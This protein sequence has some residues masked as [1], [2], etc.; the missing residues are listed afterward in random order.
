M[1]TWSLILGACA[2]VS[3]LL[4]ILHDA[5][6]NDN[7]GSAILIAGN[8]VVTL[9]R[10]AVLKARELQK[11]RRLWFSQAT[12]SK[13][14]ANLKTAV[15]TSS[16]SLKPVRQDAQHLIEQT[17]LIEQTLDLIEHTLAAAPPKTEHTLA[18]LPNIEQAPAASPPEIEQ[19]LAAPPPKTEHTLAPPPK[20]EQTPAAPPPN[21][22]QTPAALPPTIE[23]DCCTATE[24]VVEQGHPGFKNSRRAR[25]DDYG[26]GHGCAWLRSLR[27]RDYPAHN[28]QI[29]SG[30]KLGA[31][32]DKVWT[33][34]S[35]NSQ[36]S[37]D[38]HRRAHAA[39]ISSSRTLD[40]EP[41]CTA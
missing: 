19:V 32:G 41:V 28:T 11:A 6:K 27:G 17:R 39:G 16:S 1:F 26:N 31:S 30:C 36:G 14:P 5:T 23:R 15:E 25:I 38:A 21:T 29:A 7:E 40:Q 35:K 22:E 2:W 9:F 37:L 8:K 18:P 20:I 34:G 10:W 4:L 13:P 12:V 33:D 3:L 24:D